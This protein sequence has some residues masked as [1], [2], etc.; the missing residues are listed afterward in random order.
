MLAE[1]KLPVQVSRWPNPTHLEG[2]LVNLN[3]IV[4]L[5]NIQAHITKAS[6]LPGRSSEVLNKAAIVLL[7]ACWEA[8][9]EDLA[10]TAFDYL[11]G[12][13]RRADELPT[14]VLTLASRAL[15]ASNDEREVWRLA[16]VG[17]RVVLKEH[18]A[19]TLER[20]VGKLNTPRPAQVDALFEDLIGLS[21]IS[22][23]WRWQNATAFRNRSRVEELITLRGEIA[24]RVRASQS[25][26]LSSVT[27]AYN[28]IWGLAV[29][30]SNKV[31][32]YLRE[33]C[34]DFPWRR[35]GYG[36]IGARGSRLRI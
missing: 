21:G 5:V 29:T 1:L 18:R 16:D 10:T 28:L 22:T 34:G 23:A 27:N 24:H 20:Y 3:E 8:Y 14:K 15:R 32:T 9:V 7:V 17:W 30:S 31:A 26:R 13:S 2:L 35:A 12:H 4:R 36:G 11:V 25:V 6:V 19:T 33:R